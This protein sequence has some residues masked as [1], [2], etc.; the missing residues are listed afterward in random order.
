M[1]SAN[2]SCP[3]C[4]VSTTAWISS[5]ETTANSSGSSISATCPISFSAHETVAGSTI[6]FSATYA[7]SE[8]GEAIFRSSYLAI[9]SGLAH[10]VMVSS[11]ASFCSVSTASDQ[12]STGADSVVT[13]STGAGDGSTAGGVVEAFLTGP[14]S[15]GSNTLSVDSILSQSALARLR[16]SSSSV[17]ALLTMPTCCSSMASAFRF[18]SKPSSCDTDLSLPTTSKNTSSS[19]TSSA[20]IAVSAIAVSLVIGAFGCSGL[21]MG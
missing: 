2:T 15:S 7:T 17:T 20:A 16:V 18:K 10:E 4:G 13:V 8:A 21:A 6:S 5:D 9:A 14:K 12:S 1:S 3:A 11:A 19:S